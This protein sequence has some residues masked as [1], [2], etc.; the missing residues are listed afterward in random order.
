MKHYPRAEALPPAWDA[1][2]GTHFRS[3]GFLEHCERHNPCHQRYYG[4]ERDGELVA[5]CIAYDLTL[6]LLTYL[7]TG[8]GGAASAGGD[9]AV[10]D[11][12]A[13]AHRRQLRSPL[14]MTVIGVPCSVAWPGLLGAPKHSNPLL[15][16]VLE[17]ER[18][19]VLGLNSDP[20]P[21][22]T[23]LVQ[24]PTLPTV[25]LE[26]EL[27][28]FDGY[29]AALRSDYRRR[30][31]R[32]AAAMAGAQRIVGP[33]SELSE[34]GYRLYLG[35][36]ERSD[37]KLEKLSHG[38]FTALPAPFQLTR[39]ELRG[40]LLG[41]HISAIERD[42]ATFFMGGVDQDLNERYRVYF[43]LLF[44]VIRQGIE[45]GCTTIDLG[46]TAEVPKLRT[47]AT[48][49]PRGMFAWSRRGLMRGLLGRAAP[50]LTYGES[51]EA[52]RVFKGQE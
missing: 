15:A 4:L 34:R 18:G 41:W 30:H 48:L 2:A 11:G 8:R 37:A 50:W 21:T 24:G 23:K 36:Y 40:A 28:S 13:A 47:G 31:R 32:I 33:C 12:V 45:A 42:R 16:A 7:G 51:F 29:L 35:A 22:I 25:I 9:R 20:R 10:G 44:D 5:G 3:R 19:L 49:E 6:D 46:Q 26:H 17:R 1:L 38:F 14:R 39:Y 27:S 52:P 43:N